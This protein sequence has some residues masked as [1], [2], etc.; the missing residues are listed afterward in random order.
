[1]GVFGMFYGLHGGYWDAVLKAGQ[2]PVLM[3]VLRQQNYQFRINAAQRFSY[4]PFDRSVFVNLRPQDLHVL[5]GPEPAWQRDARNTDDLLRFVDRRLPDRPFF[6]CLFLESSHANY[7]FRDETAKIRPY[8]VN[9]NYLTTDFQ[10]QMPLIKNRYL[11]AVREVDTQIGRLLQHLENQ[12]LLENTAV[13]VL[14]DHGEEFMERSRWGH[15]TEFNRYQ[16]GTVAVLSIPGQA[17]R[18]VRGITSHID[19]P[20]TLLPL[21]GVRNPPA[22]TRWD[23]TCSQ[24]TTIATMR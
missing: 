13:V 11:N 20:A 14:G 5:D 23:R 7:S 12:H 2:P 1:M 3:E 9:F 17:P 15:N 18:A 21:L 8:L 16:T 4:P 10:A 24:R 22:T 6:A 19:L